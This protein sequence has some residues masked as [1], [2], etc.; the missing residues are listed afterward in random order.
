MS[1]HDELGSFIVEPGS[2]SAS[3]NEKHPLQQETIELAT[4]QCIVEGGLIGD[5]RKLSSSVEHLLEENAVLK[6]ELGIEKRVN[7]AIVERNDGL[8]NRVQRAE[9]TLRQAGY[10][11]HGGQLWKPP[12]GPSA[13]PYLDKITALKKE[14]ARRPRNL[15]EHWLFR[16]LAVAVAIETIIIFKLALY[17]GSQWAPH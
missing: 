13:I 6:R 10:T 4:G 2:A 11:D 12:L 14:L 15:M 17:V 8:I 7:Q 5:D 1:K 3:N 16:A 9:D